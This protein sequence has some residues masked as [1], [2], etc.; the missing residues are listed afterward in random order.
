MFKRIVSSM[1]IVVLFSL[2][3][4]SEYVFLKDGSILKGNIVAD[5][6]D[7]VK[8]KLKSGKYRTISRG[9]VMRILY[10]E[11]YMGKI[12]VRKVDGRGVS[13][14]MV[15]EDRDSYTF[16]KE[17][18]KPQEFTLR[19]SQVLFM[20]RGNPAGLEGKAST[21]SIDLKWFSPYSAVDKYKI[22][23]KQKREK[24]F[25]LVDTTRDKD[26]TV[27]DLK[28]HT[29]YEFYVTAIDNQGDESLPSNI[30]NIKTKNILPTAPEVGKPQ[31]LSGGRFR[32]SWK[33][34]LDEDGRVVK[35]GIY[36]VYDGKKKLLTH[37]K[38]TTYILPGNLSFDTIHV[39]SVD[40][41][42]G[43]SEE[44]RVW[45]EGG[46]RVFLTVGGAFIY[47][48]GS[49]GELID[50]TYGAVL[51][52]GIRN[53]FVR[54]LEFYI[55]GG[56]YSLNLKEADDS[57]NNKL[58]SFLM[59]PVIFNGGYAFHFS[60][61]FSITP[62]LSGGVAMLK[63]DYEYVDSVSSEKKSVKDF[64]TEPL[65]GAGVSFNFKITENFFT[66]LDCD[67]RMIF[68]K[69]DKYSYMSAILGLGI[70]F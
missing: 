3:A 19:R 42:E 40:N 26:F 22:Y 16:R 30:L 39:V 63:R 1:T 35:Y 65:A 5:L 8:I 34:S 47:P 58:N 54:N 28:S 9:S 68:E 7:S 12:Y 13:C 49:F 37:T 56:A 52:V 48:F 27:E 33:R 11:I 36:Q 25:K 10:T 38:K 61:W 18:Y 41:L 51:K 46:K 50:G 20:A 15:D 31:K 2:P 4:W 14:Y 21:K 32:I 60:S 64:M 24:K 43:E 23:M 29:K 70:S 17:L 67:Y 53:Y 45:F 6:A 57:S 69:S 44:S 55:E 62:R 59:A 66:Y